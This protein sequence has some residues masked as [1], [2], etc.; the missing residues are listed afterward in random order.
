[1]VK[2]VQFSSIECQAKQFDEDTRTQSVFWEFVNIPVAERIGSD[3]II[4]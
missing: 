1:M 3:H 4:S 2:K